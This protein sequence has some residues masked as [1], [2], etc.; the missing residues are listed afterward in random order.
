MRIPVQF[1]YH[2]SIADRD[3][4]GMQT[5]GRRAPE[6]PAAWTPG[7]SVDAARLLTAPQSGLRRTRINI[8]RAA[9]RCG[10]PWRG[11]RLI[12]RSYSSG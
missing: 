8:E 5:F 9:W 7:R 10:S 4:P 1:I 11:G 3:D 6:M 12:D 2:G